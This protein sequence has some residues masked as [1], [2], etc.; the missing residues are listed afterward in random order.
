MS[1]SLYEIVYQES[2]KRS[3]RFVCEAEWQANSVKEDFS[4]RGTA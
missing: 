2:K 4:S 1:M 3:Y